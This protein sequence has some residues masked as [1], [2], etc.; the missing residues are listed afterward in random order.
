MFS[1]IDNNINK[2]Q[3]NIEFQNSMKAAEPWSSSEMTEDK[4]K[5]RVKRALID[6]DY[7]DK[8]YFP[9]DMYNG[10]KESSNAMIDDIIKSF[11]VP[12]VHIFC[13]PRGHG[14]TVTAKKK[15]IHELLNF[16]IDIGGTYSEDLDNAQNLLRDIAFL[17]LEN[18]RIKYDFN[19]IVR[20]LNEDKFQF[21]TARP[22]CS[23]QWRYL[24]AF[25]SKRSVR[26][27]TRVFKR[28]RKILGDDIETLDSS[29]T[30]EAVEHRLKRIGETYDSLT[31]NDAVFIILANNFDTRSAINQ[32]KND[33]KNGILVKGWKFHLYKAW[34]DGK[35]L[36]SKFKKAKNEAQFKAMLNVRSES[37]YQ[38]N[39]QQNPIPPEGILFKREFYKEFE[40]LPDDVRGVSYVDPN[41]S[42][43]GKG[44]TTAMANMLYSPSTGFFYVPDAL[45]QSYSDSDKLLN[46]VLKITY[47]TKNIYALGFDGNVNQESIWTN[48]IKQWCYKHQV[49]FRRVE[50]KR[51]NVDLLAKNFQYAWNE[52]LI[53][54]AQDFAKSKQ[55]EKF[56]NQVFSFSGK[57]AN[58]TDDAP[59]VLISLFE[60]IHERGFVRRKGSVI[61]QNYVIDDTYS[62]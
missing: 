23:K 45:C 58:K 41:L 37:D 59:D 44:D 24:Q 32:L 43:K 35:P 12:G 26:G 8:T 30:A 1:S 48:N 20:V 10:G 54:F 18:D 17:I 52:G 42:K 2:F 31:G 21:M 22:E 47:S 50:Y 6:Y 34:N 7:F 29:M 53:L 9:E 14:K 38:G 40:K 27:Y 3:D 13:G 15:F 61:N 56:L 33:Y 5:A 46:D 36:W 49:P 16:S 51:Y 25:S 60:F 28:P 57:K 11:E 19:P 39:Y 55:G 62:Y 4:R